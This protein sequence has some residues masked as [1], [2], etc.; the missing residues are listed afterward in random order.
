M[1][2]SRVSNF[3]KGLYRVSQIH[4]IFEFTPADLN[5]FHKDDSLEKTK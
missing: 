5:L 1:G 3:M 4:I 2:F